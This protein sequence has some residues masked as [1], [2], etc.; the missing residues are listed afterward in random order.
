MKVRS[1]MLWSGSLLAAAV[2][3]A[4][5]SD[6]A[7]T[8]SLAK[9]VVGQEITMGNGKV[10]SW[11]KLDDA[12]NPSAVGVT[13]GEAALTGLD[14][15]A[16]EFALTLPAEK[17]TMAVDHIT[18]DWNP[19]GH[20]PAPIYTLPHFDFHFYTVTQ[21][22][23]DAIAGG[24][25]TITISPDFIPAGYI[26]DPVSIPQMGVHYVDSTAGEFHGSLFDK[27]FIYGYSGANHVFLEPMI[28][29]AYLQG[30]K[31]AGTPVSVA[32]KQP[33][34]FQKTGVYYPTYYDISYD[35]TAKEYTV[36]LTKP[37]KR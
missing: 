18:V 21:A 3:A 32:Y 14:T 1:L 33:A 2:F 30:R 34:K 13:F 26:G 4:G 29:L 31:A 27:T 25:A 24:P 16:Q 11:I 17:S 8:P 28:T 19:G 23:Q 15:V 35:A 20:P 7:T 6:D 12:G 37:V 22:V 5:C 36:S 9:T 10:R